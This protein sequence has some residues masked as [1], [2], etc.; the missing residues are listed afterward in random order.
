MNCN[1]NKLLVGCSEVGRREDVHEDEESA[2]PFAGESYQM[3]RLSVADAEVF[4]RGESSELSS[5]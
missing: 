1:K 4:R 3:V 2:E 5:G